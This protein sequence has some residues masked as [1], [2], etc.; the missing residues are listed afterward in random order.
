MISVPFEKSLAYLKKEI[1]KEWDESNEQSPED[2]SYGSTVKVNWRCARDHVYSASITSRTR[3]KNPSGCPYC[4]GKL[5]IIGETDLLSQR[6]DIAKEWDESNERNPEEF[7]VGANAKVNWRCIK[8]HVYSATIHN[9]TKKIKPT[10]CPYCA[11]RLP[12]KGETDLLSQRPDIAKEWD[13]SNEKDPEEFTVGAHAKVS[14]RCTKGHIYLARIKDRT[15]KKDSR[16]CPYCAGKLPIIGETDLLSQRPDIA[17]EWDESNEQGPEEFTVGSGAKVNWRCV[18]G[19]V[20]PAIIH[21]RTR[22]KNSSGCP[23]CVGK[24]PIVGETDLL[25]QRADIAKEWDESNEQGPEEFTVSSGA[26]VN[27]KCPEGHV[28]TATI[29]GRTRKNQPRGCPYCAGRLPIKGETDLLSQRPDIAEEWDESNEKGPEEYTVGSGV[30]VNWRCFKGHVYPAVISIR[31]RRNNPSGCPYCAGR[32]PIK[33]ETDLLS[34]RPDIAK[35]WDDSNEQSPEDFTVGS[36]KEVKWRCL[37][38]HVYAAR[39]FHRTKKNKPQ[40]CPYCAG[41]LPIKGE[42]DLLSQ[43]PEIVIFWD[44]SR[45]RKGPEEYTCFTKTKVNWKCKD[46]GE[47]WRVSIISMTKATKVHRCK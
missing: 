13:E 10:E 23:Y 2:F 30:K 35:E 24:L 18:K 20:Y 27:W 36:D 7:T 5:P 40:G 14:W 1:S 3:K 6:P 41:R 34:Q 22:K 32:L 29:C 16:G 42:T 8:G 28:Y 38:G 31:T 19:H 45:N 25:S 39:I 9:R 17:K 26:K 4:A 12:I 37:K 43:R 44:F 46:C 15:R 47:T 11:G 21:N 33:G